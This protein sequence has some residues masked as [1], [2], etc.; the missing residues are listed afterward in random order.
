MSIKHFE[1]ATIGAENARAI[2]AQ[3]GEVLEVR[4][5]QIIVYED[6][7][8][9]G[10]YFLEDVLFAVGRNGNQMRLRPYC[11][12]TPERIAEVA[13][14]TWSEEDDYEYD[15]RRFYGIFFK[16]KPDRTGACL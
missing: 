2:L 3:L 8:D 10:D 6:H 9:H 4:S 5:K 7:E 1:T 14:M 11:G 12:D 16:F 15:D 13:T